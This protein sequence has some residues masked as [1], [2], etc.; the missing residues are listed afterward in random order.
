MID[1]SIAKLEDSYV[2]GLNALDCRTGENLAREQI[3]SEDKKHVLAALGKAA[4]E[5][6]AKLGE[7]FSS[8]QK[9][10]TPIEQATTLFARGPRRLLPWL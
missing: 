1:G 3:T 2:V 7:S 5:L 10:D 6:R 9:Y 4:Q 8:I